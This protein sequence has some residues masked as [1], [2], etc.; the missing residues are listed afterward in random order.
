LNFRATYQSSAAQPTIRS[1]L[2]ITE[3]KSISEQ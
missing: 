2:P 1:R 3:R